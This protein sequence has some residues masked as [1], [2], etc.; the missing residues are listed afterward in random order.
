MHCLL[1]SKIRNEREDKTMENVTFDYKFYR[2]PKRFF[3]E[4]QF[5]DMTN[6]AK[7][8][9]GILLD[10]K[11]MSDSNGGAW[12]DEYGITYIIFTI[13][14]RKWNLN[15]WIRNIQAE[16]LWKDIACKRYQRYFICMMNMKSVST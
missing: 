5:S 14:K 4:E 11:G 16:S 10:R 15:E 7:V 12:R 3:K 9:Y 2:I 13:L 1:S 6:A 8:L